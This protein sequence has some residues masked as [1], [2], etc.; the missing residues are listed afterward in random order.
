MLLQ[1]SNST[2]ATNA[3][4]ATAAVATVTAKFPPPEG[5]TVEVGPAPVNPGIVWNGQVYGEAR[6]DGVDGEVNIEVRGDAAQLACCQSTLPP[7]APPC[8]A[9]G[10]LA[11]AASCA[12]CAAKR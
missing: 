12:Y 5:P 8:L 3:T 1:A 2:N 10:P 7:P 9:A 4:N 11:V 6:G